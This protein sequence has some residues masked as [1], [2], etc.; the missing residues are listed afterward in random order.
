MEDKAQ[1]IAK[2]G[3][4]KSIHRIKLPFRVDPTV[5]KLRCLGTNDGGRFAHIDLAER[6]KLYVEK[7]IMIDTKRKETSSAEK[8]KYDTL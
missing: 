2:Q 1:A 6:K 5:L 4:M 3:P 8:R 7:V